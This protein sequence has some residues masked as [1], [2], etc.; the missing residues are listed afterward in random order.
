M[1]AGQS[2]I[3]RP[4]R[5]DQ[6]LEA[7]LRSGHLAVTNFEGCVRPSRGWKLK[8]RAASGVAAERLGDLAAMGF[9]LVSLANNHAGDWG[10]DGVLA[11]LEA[12][13][14]AGLQVAGAAPC[15]AWAR[16]GARVETEAGRIA[17]LAFDIGPWPDHVG[18]LDAGADHPPRPGIARIRVARHAV[19]PD[20]LYRALAD[21]AVQ[22]GELRLAALRVQ[23]GF[24]EPSPSGVLAAFG[25]EARSGERAGV[26][27]EPRQ[28]DLA[29]A[30]AAVAEA[31]ADSAAVLVVLHNHVWERDW[32]LA[33]PFLLE[34]A[35][36]LAQAG[37]DLVAG[38]GAPVLQPLAWVEGAR[39]PVAVLPCLGNFLFHSGRHGIRAMPD[40]WRSLVVGVALR[41]GAAPS[42][43]LRPVTLG[44]VDAADAGA[45]RLAAG[46]EAEQ[47]LADFRAGS[48]A[49]PCR[50]TE[51][52]AGLLRLSRD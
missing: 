22:A 20:A 37:A 34:I 35:G 48:D 36:R 29:A 15:L 18:A 52:G 4:V 10:P 40:A 7:T 42:L 24:Q 46:L 30:E 39:G 43:W 38:H 47:I 11:T 13:Q 12:A 3:K 50:W 16:A 33:P 17:V 51:E 14:V 41:Q 32:A 25:L 8:D 1:L 6:A 5:I 45:P 9:G 31:A 44:P 26:R 49:G 2:L 19:L 28:A 21:A 27:V 23:A